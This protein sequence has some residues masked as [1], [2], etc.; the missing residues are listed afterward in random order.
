[1]DRRKRLIILIALLTAMTLAA[2][3]VLRGMLAQRSGAEEAASQ[4]PST[5]EDVTAD[6]PKDVIFF[7]S[8]YQQEPGWDAPKDS[9]EAIL[10]A[11]NAGGNTVKNTIICG[12]YTNDAKLYDYQLSPE[13]SIAEI[14]TVVTENCPDVNEEDMI[15]VQ[16]NHDKKTDSLSETG[17]HE[18][19]NY[20]VYVLGTEDSFP[21]K[22]GRE[23]E[24][25][26]RVIAAADVMRE[27]F[28][29]LIEKGE[30]RPVFIAGHVPL[31][32]TAR[33]SSRHTTGDNMYSAY[34]FNVVNEAARS[35]D[36][37]Y[38]TG[39]NHSKGWDCYMGGSCIFKKAGDILLIP[40]SEGQV[41]NTDK[42]T[43][44]E[45]N[46]TYMN[47][48]YTGYYMNCGTEEMLSGEADEYKAADGTLTGTVCEI[49]DDEIVITRYDAEGTHDLCAAGE[50]DPY[51]G[52]IDEDLIDSKYYSSAVHEPAHIIRRASK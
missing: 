17:L 26:E 27:C 9:L 5:S 6:A 11:V 18:Y 46:F 24:S 38:M 2:A 47:A 20:L 39:H 31:H 13:E 16:G 28:D 19:D 43:E 37:F 15:F 35:L 29:G 44:E 8:D 3:I 12:D 32:F 21:W 48:G 52:G 41:S 23:P 1:M 7:A 4:E 25:E 42:F 45:L 34:I 22:Q 51:K 50:P 40:D 14:R 10:K 49:T 36:I 30:T 33:T